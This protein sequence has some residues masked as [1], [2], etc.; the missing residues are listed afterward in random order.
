MRKILDK[1]DSA[2]LSAKLSAKKFLTDEHG[3]T[4][5]ISIAIIMVVVIAVAVVFIGFKD[6]VIGW[7]GSAIDELGDALGQ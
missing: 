3:D 1:I 5:F 7:F 4:N 2:L 6:Q